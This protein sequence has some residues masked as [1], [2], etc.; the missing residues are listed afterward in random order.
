MVAVWT[1]VPSVA[2]ATVSVTRAEEMDYPKTRD[3]RRGYAN[4][5]P[6]E[7]GA[8]VSLAEWVAARAVEA[9]AAAGAGTQG[10]WMEGNSVAVVKA[11]E[12]ASVKAVMK[13]VVLEVTKAARVA[14]PARRKTNGSLPLL[15]A[16]RAA[17]G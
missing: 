9:G 10:A 12:A 3:Q 6:V 11:L 4:R 17:L 5:D 13:A 15:P 8:G 7:K 2:E 14:P 16:G 1:A